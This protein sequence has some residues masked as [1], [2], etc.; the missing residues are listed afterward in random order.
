MFT[1]EIIESFVFIALLAAA[2]VS[3]GLV[4]GRREDRDAGSPADISK[5]TRTIGEID[6]D[7]RKKTA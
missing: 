4:L 5:G 2:I 7:M 1:W 6:S 3:Y